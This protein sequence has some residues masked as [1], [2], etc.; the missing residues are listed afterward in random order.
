MALVIDL[1]RDIQQIIPKCPINAIT[2]AYVRA[3]RSF[4]GQTRWY[5]TALTAN[6][7]ANVVGYSLGSDPLLEVID[8]PIAQIKDTNG[9]IHPL[10]PSDPRTFDPNTKP[11]MPLT[12]AYMPEGSVVFHPKPDKV[13]EVTITL[14]VQPK[15]GVAEIPDPLL[16]KWRLA[17]EHGALAFLL[18]LPEAW[19]DAQ[20][21]AFHDRE[22]RSAVNNAKADIARGWQSGTVI[23]RT[24]PFIV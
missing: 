17:I 4:C 12:Y 18:M 7:T 9:S 5:V 24:K 2:A 1:V 23:A 19:K 13:Y 20:A 11:A 22:F 6:L 16:N 15:D 21:A 10:H 8:A 14:A 3:A